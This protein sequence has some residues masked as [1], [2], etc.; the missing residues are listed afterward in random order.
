MQRKFK[1]NVDGKD[2]DVTVV[3]VTDDGGS[4]YPDRT[5][6]HTAPVQPERS[7]L[8][9]P[10]P[11]APTAG[12]GDVASPLAGIVLAIL[13]EVGESVSGD[14]HVV[15]LEAMKT[16]TVVTAGRAGSITAIAVAPNQAVDA[17]QPLLTVG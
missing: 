17:G 11:T 3:E 4:L 16:K 7:A 8:A 10:A 14:T 6:M 9:S 12:P 1:I 15:I 2:Y 5:T 13:V